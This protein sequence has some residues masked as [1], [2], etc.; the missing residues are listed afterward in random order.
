VS[1]QQLDAFL[2]FAR[3]DADLSVRLQQP[4][5]LAD[6]LS[7]AVQAGYAVE[8]ADVIAAM[9]REDEKLSDQ[10][11]QRRAG[12]DARKLRNFIPG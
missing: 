6:L 7:L 12:E 3:G 4:M 11:L 5:D 10:D 2:A 8:E 9:V 1:L